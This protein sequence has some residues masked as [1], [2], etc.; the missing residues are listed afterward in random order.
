L[1]MSGVLT[2]AIHIGNDLRI[3]SGTGRYPWQAANG[4]TPLPPD[5]RAQLCRENGVGAWNAGG[6][7]TG[8]CAYVRSARKT[9]RR[10]V[11]GVGKVIFVD[12]RK[13]ALGEFAARCLNA[14]GLGARLGR[15][16][17]ALKPNYGLLKGIPTN[18]PLLGPQWRLRH[19][20]EGPC[21]PLEAR[22]GLM[23]VSPVLPMTG[24]DAENL[25]H[26]MEPIY[27]RFGFELLVT[28]TMI[29]ERAMI[30][31]TN[32]AFDKDVAEETAAATQCYDALLD[33]C[34]ANGYY[35]Y[36]ATLRGM[37]DIASPDDPFWQI[38]AEIKRALDPG[39]IIAP[40]RYIPR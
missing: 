32:V 30:A 9:L 19:P 6:S 23:W 25:L 38:A 4:K 18:E 33:A 3:L 17:E 27:T 14:V 20:P 29:N 28:F 13:L 7:F 37:S 11:A 10:A 31:I 5:V 16:L 2:S 21:N 12:D 22:C 26:I 36:R 15:Q 40:G 8:T 35:P 24:A 39:Q 1:R 34:I